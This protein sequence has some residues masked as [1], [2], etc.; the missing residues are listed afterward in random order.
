MVEERKGNLSRQSVRNIASLDDH[1]EIAVDGQAKKLAQQIG[2]CIEFN[3]HIK[4]KALLEEQESKVDV[5]A[6]KFER[7]M[8][9][10]S[11]AARF[12]SDQCFDVVYAHAM[13]SN[14]SVDYQL[15]PQLGEKV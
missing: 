5:T 13:K 7:N 1:T 3:D 6:L 2:D 10:L 8:S 9:A 4:L 11:W 14:F 12:S 15:T